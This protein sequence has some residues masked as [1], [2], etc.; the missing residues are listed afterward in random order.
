MNL[1]RLL[2]AFAIGCTPPS[3]IGAILLSSMQQIVTVT[4]SNEVNVLVVGVMLVFFIVA[5]PEGILG[6]LRKVQWKRS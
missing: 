2:I 3:V 6:L 1:T 4:I 5:A